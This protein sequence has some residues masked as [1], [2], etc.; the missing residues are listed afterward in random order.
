MKNELEIQ[1]NNLLKNREEL[2]DFMEELENKRKGGL[3][4]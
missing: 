2:N 3:N 4:S 1:M